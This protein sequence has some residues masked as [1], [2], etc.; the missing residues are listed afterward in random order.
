MA[1]E[2]IFLSVLQRSVAVTK[3]I[4]VI[5]ETKSSGFDQE[6]IRL[7]DARKDILQ[8][9]ETAQSRLSGKSGEQQRYRLRNK[10]QQELQEFY[11]TDAHAQRLLAEAIE[12]VQATL[13]TIQHGKYLN[14]YLSG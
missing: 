8:E 7:Y 3:E 6:L 13:R 1:Y 12:S 5:L 2:E 11:D 10:Y 4:I 9:L 14:A